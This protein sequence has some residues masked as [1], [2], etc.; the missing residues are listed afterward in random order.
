MVIIVIPGMVIIVIPGLG[1]QRWVDP[2]SQ[3]SSSLAYLVSF[4]PKK[5]PCHTFT[6]RMAPEE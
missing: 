6:K 3:F 4:R 5:R 1:R 2:W